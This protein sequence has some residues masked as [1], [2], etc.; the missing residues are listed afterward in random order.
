M[1]PCDA[2]S[3]FEIAVLGGLA[4]KCA[5]NGDHRWNVIVKEAKK[6]VG[7]KPQSIGDTQ[8]KSF[9][10]SSSLGR[11]QDEIVGWAESLRAEGQADHIV[12]L[13]TYLM[14]YGETNR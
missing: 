5:A 8:R 3:T 13:G 11:F 2:L 4:K 1:L 10:P 12:Q 14:S 9:G 7:G 6:R